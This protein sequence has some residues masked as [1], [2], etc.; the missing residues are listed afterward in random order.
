MRLFIHINSTGS[1]NPRSILLFAMNMGN[2]FQLL[3]D[4]RVEHRYCS[5]PKSITTV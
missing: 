1:T 3:F 2:K 4:A 5:I